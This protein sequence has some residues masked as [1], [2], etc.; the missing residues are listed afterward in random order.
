MAELA[1]LS[2]VAGGGGGLGIIGTLVGGVGQIL[3]GVAALQQGRFAAEVARANAQAAR[4]QAAAEEIRVR[5]ERV[6]RIG[7]TRAAFGAAGVTLEGS[8]LDVLAE[9]ALEAEEDAL[10]VRFGGRVRARQF[11]LEATLAQQAGTA[12]LFGGLAGGLGTILT[13]GIFQP[14]AAA[15]PSF[16][17]VGPL[18]SETFGRS[19]T[20]G[21]RFLSEPP[22]ITQFA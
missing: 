1:L 11:G 21:L 7:A 3:G 2:A 20:G 14:R 17:Q 16:R 9:Q 12:G 5:R 13:S 8:P 6:R 10:L 4:Q 15:V 22:R 18:T 19:P